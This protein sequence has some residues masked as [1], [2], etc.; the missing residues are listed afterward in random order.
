MHDTPAILR[1][2]EDLLRHLPLI[3]VKDTAV[4]AICHGANLAVPG[5]AKLS[6][7]IRRGDLVGVFTGK[8]RSARPVEGAHDDG[9]NRRGKVAEPRRTRVGS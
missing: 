4:D 9:R 6:A 8:R 3:V 2:I 1:P 7:H 5:V